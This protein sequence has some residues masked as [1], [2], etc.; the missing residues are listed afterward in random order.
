MASERTLATKQARRGTL[1]VWIC[2]SC[3]T[4]GCT[5]SH[6]TDGKQR[7]PRCRELFKEQEREIVM[8]EGFK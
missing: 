7:C 3:R 1:R 8:R 4:Q 6:C 5:L 2:A